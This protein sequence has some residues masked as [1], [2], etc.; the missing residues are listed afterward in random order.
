MIKYAFKEVVTFR[1]ASKADAQKIGETLAKIE[2]DSGALTPTAIWQAAKSPKHPLH[3]HYNWN[4]EEA[5]IAHWEDVSRSIVQ[6]IR[7]VNDDGRPPSIA[8]VS[9]SDK[10]GTSYRSMGEVL[11]SAELQLATLK[12]AERD[13]EAWQKRYHE[14][15]D[16]CEM[17]RKTR[18]VLA[19]RRS[20]LEHES[21]VNH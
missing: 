8:Y 4:V 16:A 12:A 19:E 18:D 6:S 11:G 14:L 17:I 1:N 13:L 15:I 20:K 21:R 7:V 3:K 9:I 2:A 10:K 5:A